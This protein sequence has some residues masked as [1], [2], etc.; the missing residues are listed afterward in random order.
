MK[1]TRLAAFA[2]LVSAV[3]ASAAP[4]RPDVLFVLVDSLKASHLGCY[5]YSRGTSPNLDRF[6]SRS[7]ATR[8]IW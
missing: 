4:S 7:T 8:R 1:S 5:G 6:T 3:A 2:V